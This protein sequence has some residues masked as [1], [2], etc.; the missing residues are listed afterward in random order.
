VRSSG[1][2][3]LVGAVLALVAGA[4]AAVASSSGPS[5]GEVERG[6]EFQRLVG[7]LGLGPTLDLSRCDADFD[8]RVGPECP[9]RH[10]AIPGG[11]VFCPHHAG[12]VLFPPP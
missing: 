10:G 5:P 11:D 3:R 7:G 2:A 1:P 12:S 4:A 9:D 8:R 6:R